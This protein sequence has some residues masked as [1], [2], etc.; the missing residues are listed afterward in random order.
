[1][2]FLGFVEVNI[3]AQWLTTIELEFNSIQTFTIE[4]I[5]HNDIPISAN[6]ISM[7]DYHF[8]LDL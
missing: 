8:M 7:D 5:T 2:D 1:M 3:I 6:D 4:D